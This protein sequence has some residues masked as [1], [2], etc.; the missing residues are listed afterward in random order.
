MHTGGKV[1]LLT[2]VCELVFNVI[3]PVS[4]RAWSFRV[5]PLFNL[6]VTHERDIYKG[7]VMCHIY[8]LILLAV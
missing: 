2:A 1:C 5:V 7:C 3:L 6:M 4:M 8:V